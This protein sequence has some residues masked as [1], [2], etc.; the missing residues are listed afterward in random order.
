[1]G[2]F[3]NCSDDSDWVQP[4]KFRK[5]SSRLFGGKKGW[6]ITQDEY[7]DYYDFYDDDN[8]HEYD[9]NDKNMI[10]TVD[11]FGYNNDHYKGINCESDVSD[12]FLI[13]NYGN[14]PHPFIPRMG[15]QLPFEPPYFPACD[16]EDENEASTRNIEGLASDKIQVK[17]ATKSSNKTKVIGL[18]GG[19]PLT[20]KDHL[21]G[22]K[23]FAPEVEESVSIANGSVSGAKGSVPKD[24][25]SVPK[26]K[27][28]VPDVIGSVPEVK[29]SVPK[30]KGSVPKIKGSVPEVLLETQLVSLIQSGKSVKS[31]ELATALLLSLRGEDNLTDNESSKTNVLTP[32]LTHKVDK[33]DILLGHNSFSFQDNSLDDHNY[34]YSYEVCRLLECLDKLQDKNVSISEGFYLIQ[35]ICDNIDKIPAGKVES[36]FYSL[37][38]YIEHIFNG[39]FSLLSDSKL[40]QRSDMKTQ[41]LNVGGIILECFDKLLQNKTKIDFGDVKSLKRVPMFLTEILTHL[42]EIRHLSDIRDALRNLFSKV[43]DTFSQIL[44]FFS[45]LHIDSSLKYEIERTQTVLRKL[46]NPAINLDKGCFTYRGKKVN[47]QQEQLT[48]FEKEGLINSNPSRNIMFCLSQRNHTLMLLDNFL[49]RLKRVN[50]RSKAWVCLSEKCSYKVIT[51]GNVIKKSLFEHNHETNQELFKTN[52]VHSKLKMKAASSMGTPSSVIVQEVVSCEK[53]KDLSLLGTT[54]SLKQMVK[55]SRRKTQP[56]FNDLRNISDLVLCPDMFLEDDDSKESLLLFDNKSKGNRIIV[57]GRK[58]HLRMLCESDLWLGDGTFKTCPKVGKQSFGQLYTIAGQRFNRLFTF[59]RILMENKCKTSYA[60]IF[61]WIKQSAED[62][63][64]KL[65]FKM[66]LTDFELAP[67]VAKNVVFGDHIK[68]KGCRF[69]FGQAV[70]KDLNEFNLKREY[71]ANSDFQEDVRKILSLPFVPESDMERRFDDIKWFLETTESKAVKLLPRLEIYY[72]KGKKRSKGERLPPRFPPSMWSM[73]DNVCQSLPCTTNFLE[74]THNA[75]KTTLTTRNH[76]NIASFASVLADDCKMVEKDIQIQRRNPSL[77]VGRSKERKKAMA[78][79]QITQEYKT[80]MGKEDFLDW[81][82]DVGR[83]AK[84]SGENLSNVRKKSQ[85]LDSKH[86]TI[87]WIKDSHGEPKDKPKQGNNQVRLQSNKQ[88]EVAGINIPDHIQSSLFRCP[89]CSL[90]F[91]EV[92]ELKSHLSVCS[93]YV[94]QGQVDMSKL[95]GYVCPGCRTI[96]IS[97]HQLNIHL[98]S[99]FIFNNGSK[100]KYI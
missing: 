62:N 76:P 21:S 17:K 91:R 83:E 77:S 38:S 4:R 53:Y 29:G 35:D 11:N 68:S 81:I 73:V 10:I 92:V 23:G 88:S 33:Q 54:S 19:S 60:Q 69:H 82:D 59:L 48:N 71:F 16:D 95:A 98:T 61:K 84:M 49:L 3:S 63:N 41:L 9:T 97:K 30:V 99:C 26:D 12:F 1:M 34:C 51:V 44:Y 80:D 66:L 74:G 45:Y 25:G 52:L 55:R 75:Y 22:D 94:S 65:G 70:M 78:L 31:K 46:S 36:L 89:T 5:K 39:I 64:W 93:H 50:K 67:H 96:L 7:F 72:V 18:L 28:S 100:Q 2:Q 87:H 20:L 47:I 90:T 79:K 15:V 85:Q 40:D 58:V 27:V 14:P 43:N 24:K 6:E 57:I 86:V 37:L 8:I 42:D 56:Q 13:W 32:R